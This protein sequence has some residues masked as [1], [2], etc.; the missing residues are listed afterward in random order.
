MVSAIYKISSNFPANK[1]RAAIIPTRTFATTFSVPLLACTSSAN[2]GLEKPVLHCADICGEAHKP[3]L[4]YQFNLFEITKGNQIFCTLRLP[5]GR[6]SVL[7]Y[8]AAFWSP[9]TSQNYQAIPLLCFSFGRGIQSLQPLQITRSILNTFQH[10]FHSSV[11]DQCVLGF[12]FVVCCLLFVVVFVCCLLFV[13]CRLRPGVLS[14]MQLLFVVVC[15]LLFASWGSQ[16]YACSPLS[17]VA[18]R[19]SPLVVVVCR[20]PLFAACCCS[21]PG[22]LSCTHVHRLPFV[23]CCCCSP[24]AVCVLGFSVVCMFTVVVCCCLLFTDACTF[25]SFVLLG[26]PVD[27]CVFTAVYQCVIH[28]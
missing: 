1:V 25:T 16:L 8:L 5:E 20:S 23:V 28:R 14:C 27:A 22:V 21:R 9:D 4:F 3:V 2:N 24:P 17:F 26:F 11:I 18:R 12:L 15:F 10:S 13:V 7:G 19:P 6:Y